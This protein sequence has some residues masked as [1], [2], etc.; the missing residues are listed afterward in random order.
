M[1]PGMTVTAFGW[2]WSV[3]IRAVYMV[4]VEPNT[5][6]RHVSAEPS[7]GGILRYHASLGI[8]SAHRNRRDLWYLGTNRAY[9]RYTR[10][11]VLVGGSVR[12]YLSNIVVIVEIDWSV[13]NSVNAIRS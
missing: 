10:T 3:R 4:W 11:S 1:V 7:N 9:G 12:Y 6:R 8:T 13:M 5:G 2:E